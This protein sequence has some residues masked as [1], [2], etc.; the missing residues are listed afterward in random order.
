MPIRPYPH[1]VSIKWNQRLIHYFHPHHIRNISLSS[2]KHQIAP[3][4]SYSSDKAGK[5]EADRDMLLVFTSLSRPAMKIR[6]IL[7]GNYLQYVVVCIRNRATYHSFMSKGPISLQALC[8]IPL[9][10]P[11]SLAQLIRH[12]IGHDVHIDFICLRYITLLLS[13]ISI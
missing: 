5:R 12:S 2:P 1:L 9:D 4:R 6:I 13:V 7:P 11:E 8:Q 10:S 3:K